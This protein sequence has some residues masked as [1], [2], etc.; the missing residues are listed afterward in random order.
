MYFTYGVQIV[1]THHI[2]KIPDAIENCREGL[3]ERDKRVSADNIAYFGDPIYEYTIGQA[4][5]DGYIAL[6]EI[7]R[8]DIFLNRQGETDRG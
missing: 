7:I 1:G 8:N 2:Q 4:I 6:M 5:E 3:K